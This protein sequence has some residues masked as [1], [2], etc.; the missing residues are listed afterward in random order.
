MS[1][2]VLFFRFVSSIGL[3]ELL[4]CVSSLFQVVL[5]QFMMQQLRL[6]GLVIM[7]VQLL[8]C[9]CVCVFFSVS[10]VCFVRFWLYVSVSGIVYCRFGYV[11]LFGNGCCF[12]VMIVW[13][14]V[15]LYCVLSE[16][17]GMLVWCMQLL[18]IGLIVWL[19]FFDS[20]FY[21]CFGVLLLNEQLIRYCCRFLCSVCLLRQFLSVFSMWLFLL[22]VNVLVF[23]MKL[24]DV[25]LLK[26]GVIGN[27]FGLML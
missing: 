6:F 25:Q 27:V 22:Y 11:F 15:R 8:I 24:F 19:F 9:V 13:F 12:S 16:I 2:V 7:F 17:S 20:V 18:L 26:F 4:I 5:L 10:V 3:V 21:R 23:S 14:F 1:S